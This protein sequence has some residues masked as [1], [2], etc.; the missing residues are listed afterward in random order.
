MLWIILICMNCDVDAA[1]AQGWRSEVAPASWS[2]SETEPFVTRAECMRAI[3]RE[4]PERDWF[5]SGDFGQISKI[6]H[7]PDY[8][9]RFSSIPNHMNSS[10]FIGCFSVESP[11]S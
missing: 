1:R 7:H 11:R 2:R 8:I 10:T 6:T 9:D 5:A 4:S 3:R